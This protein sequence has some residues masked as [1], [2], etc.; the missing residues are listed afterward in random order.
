MDGVGFLRNDRLEGQESGEGSSSCFSSC[1]NDRRS[2]WPGSLACSS[3]R[4]SP[5]ALHVLFLLFFLLE[6]EVRKAA[7]EERSR[8]QEFGRNS[9]CFSSCYS[10]QALELRSNGRDHQ[11]WMP[12]VLLFFL[13]RHWI[14]VALELRKGSPKMINCHSS[15]F[16]SCMGVYHFRQPWS[17]GKDHR[18]KWANSSC[19]C[20]IWPGSYVRNSSCFTPGQ[21]MRS[22]CLPILTGSFAIIGWV[23][24]HT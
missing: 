9:S 3:R 13:L 24:G 22:T 23:G 18:L 6:H 21:I 2:V 4:G 17:F 1:F 5:E 19:A 8:S 7:P 14:L 10:C 20:I 16:S 15:C 12:I 11:N